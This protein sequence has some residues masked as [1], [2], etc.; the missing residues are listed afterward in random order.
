[1]YRPSS[2]ENLAIQARLNYILGARAYDSVFI[3]FECGH[4]TDKTAHVFVRSE[5]NAHQIGSHYS[6]HVAIAVESVLKRP[7]TAVRV[8][9]KHF[10]DSPSES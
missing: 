3:G 4:I 7:I 10:S 5:H 6:T 9:P 1:M 2:I 8:L